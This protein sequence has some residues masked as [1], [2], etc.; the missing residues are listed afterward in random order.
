VSKPDHSLRV[1]VLGGVPAALGGGGLERQI[2]RTA[3]ALRARGIDV[4]ELREAPAGWSFDVLHAFGH[5]ADVGHQLHHWR[6]CP[7]HL[8]VSP[9]VVVPPRREWRL[10]LATRLPVPAFEPRLLRRLA[11]RADRLIALTRW[12]ARLLRRVGGRATAPI[13]VIGNGV[14]RDRAPLG[15]EALERRLAVALPDRYAIVV[16]AVSPRKRQ[17]RLAAA[18]A[19]VLPLVVVGGWE[20]AAAGRE[21]FA[22]AV[23]ATG[24]LW[25]GE[26]R[27]RGEVDGLIAA[28]EALVHLSEAEGQ[29]LAVLEA[30]SLGT[31]C[32]LS[33]LPQQ[34]ELAARWPGL[35][36]IVAGEAALA[37]ALRRLPPPRPEPAAVPG[38][39]EVAAALEG[40][41]AGLDGPPRV[42][43]ERG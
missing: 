41:Y 32:V 11:T 7:A 13:D 19:G 9:V 24:G 1:G 22:R 15:R 6:R 37:E 16:G 2:A 17:A 42:W 4:R 5:T 30:L 23:E 3:A 8:V 27:E 33:D 18:L 25:L 31:R 35:V 36:A 10:R 21:D 34:R 28:A 39:D 20:G 26:L 43:G 40:V 14:D 12:E 29:S 38:W